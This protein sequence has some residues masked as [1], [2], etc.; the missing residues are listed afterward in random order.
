VVVGRQYLADMNINSNPGSNSLY[1]PQAGS[2]YGLSLPP[3]SSTSSN[4]G[5]LN[6]FHGQKHKRDTDRECAFAF[7][8][9]TEYISNS[10]TQSI[11]SPERG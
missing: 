1:Q 4:D 2:R 9:Q 7:V 6:G 8:L 11:V 3:R 10:S 5:K